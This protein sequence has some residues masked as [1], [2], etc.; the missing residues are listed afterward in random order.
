MFMK[1]KYIILKFKLHVQKSFFTLSH[2]FILWFRI[3]IS[4]HMPIQTLIYINNNE[5]GE[6]EKNN[7]DQEIQNWL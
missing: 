4:D 7:N 2:D 6:G 1:K 5:L 3:M